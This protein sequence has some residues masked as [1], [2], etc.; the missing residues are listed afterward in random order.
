MRLESGPLSTEEE[1]ELN[2]WLQAAPRHR[3]ALIRAK[4]V[5]HNLD[6]LGALAG[7]TGLQSGPE[8]DAAGRESTAPEKGLS[9]DFRRRRVVSALAASIAVA[10]VGIVGYSVFMQSHRSYAT[11]V[12]ELRRISLE[13]GSSIV[14]NSGSHVSVQFHAATREVTLDRG[15]AL[16]EVAS[17]KNRP[18]TVHTGDVSVRAVGTAFSV[19]R[20]EE[21]VSVSVTDGVVEVSEPQ[22]ALQRVAVNERATVRPTRGV[23]VTHEDHST[24]ERRL[25][26]R[27]GM[28]SFAGETLGAAVDEVNRYSR[29]KIVIDNPALRAEP[30]VG[31]FRVGDVDAFARTAAAALGAEVHAE[32]G[33]VRMTAA[34]QP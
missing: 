4:A 31:I 6:R 9:T 7:P 24:M 23:I 20:V 11:D 32:D 18:F 5:W 33:V 3:G 25:A 14:L 21:T 34:G 26:W 1:R 2:A 19:R 29:R 30:V 22:A 16:F 12:G 17:D 27:D 13:D 15:E 10:A 28:V 8:V